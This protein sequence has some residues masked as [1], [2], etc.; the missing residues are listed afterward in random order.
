MSLFWGFLQSDEGRILER[1]GASPFLIRLSQDIRI[2]SK[3][4]YAALIE[5]TQSIA[6][7][8]EGW[9]KSSLKLANGKT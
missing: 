7:Q 6:K 4:N 8:A 5:M 9:R 1:R 2:L 3:K